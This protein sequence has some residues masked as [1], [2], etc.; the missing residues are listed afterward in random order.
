[1]P[2]CR[3]PYRNVHKPVLVP[4]ILPYS[5]ACNVM[6]MCNY[7]CSHNVECHLVFKKN[8]ETILCSVALRITEILGTVAIGFASSTR[9]RMGECVFSHTHYKVTFYD[10]L[11]HPD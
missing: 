10:V 2:G 8:K 1:M 6:C 5:K 7:T 9:R 4:A 11:L 3:V